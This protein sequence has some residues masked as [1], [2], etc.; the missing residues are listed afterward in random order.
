MKIAIVS[1]TP[2]LSQ[3]DAIEIAAVLERQLGEHV[4]PAWQCAGV[5]V[6]AFPSL[7]AVPAGWSI[8][9]VLQNA[10]QAG[11]LGY[12]DVTPDGRPFAKVFTGPILFSGGSVKRGPNS[13]AVTISHEGIET[14]IDPYASFWCDAPN[15]GTE[16]PEEEAIEACDR[17]EDQAYVLDGVWMSDF[18]TS[19]AFM[20]RTDR[21]ATKAEDGP[22][23][24]LGKLA[25]PWDLTPGG[26]CIRRRGGPGGVTRM[27]NAAQLSVATLS[28]HAE[29]ARHAALFKGK[30]GRAA[31]RIAAKRIAP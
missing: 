12:H 30:L 9:A 20:V 26:Y 21:P 4:A 5:D 31:K 27:V 18:L 6:A 17:V 13:I 14:V 16:S 19:R 22:F 3:P 2:D 24:Y 15:D 25:G 11:V 8:L 29:H 10:D 28:R 1:E 23:D 7:A